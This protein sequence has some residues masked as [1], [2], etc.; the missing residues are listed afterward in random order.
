M[1][2]CP[3]L[4]KCKFLQNFSNEKC[5]EALILLYCRDDFEKCARYKIR[6]E[7]KM[8]PD[9]LWPNGEMV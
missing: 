4:E 6:S 1:K 7:G 9:N 3:N 2:E 8:P 5:A